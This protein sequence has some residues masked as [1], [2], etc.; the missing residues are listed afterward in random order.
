VYALGGTVYGCSIHGSTT[1]MLGHR[2]GCIGYGCV[3]APAV[4]GELAAYGLESCGID[5]C[6]GEVFLRRLTD[7]KVLRTAP[8]TTKLL[9]PESFQSVGSLALKRDGALAWIG[10]GTSIGAHGKDVEVRRDDRLGLALLD[11]GAAIAGGS[12][13]LHGSTV[14]WKH[15]AS[16]RSATL[17]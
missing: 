2:G 7:G 8:A 9:G 16:K 3:Q 4:A 15:G 1:Y 10:V 11:S 6:S 14:T 17:H 13:R 12:L 5:T